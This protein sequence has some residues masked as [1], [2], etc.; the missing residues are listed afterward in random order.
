M[1]CKHGLK[2]S[3]VS[4]NHR[5]FLTPYCDARLIKKVGVEVP[6]GLIE[7]ERTPTVFFLAMTTGHVIPHQRRSTEAPNGGVFKM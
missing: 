3:P 5:G 6:E 2:T 7:S 4:S 1:V